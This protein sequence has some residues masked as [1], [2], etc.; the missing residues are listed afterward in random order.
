MINI[1]VFSIMS[2]ITGDNFGLQ[3]G[4]GL[5]AILSIFRFRS[6]NFEQMDIAYFFGA[7]A[8]AT[9]NG[10]VPVGI[11][12]FAVNAIIIAAAFVVDFG[13]T[14]GRM[15]STIVTLDHIPDYLFNEKES[16]RELS[17]KFEIG[18]YGIII[19]EVDYV[20]ETAQVELHFIADKKLQGI[21]ETKVVEGLKA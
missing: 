6:E 20:K 16:K 8:L 3:A 9:V 15:Q 7:V 17:A 13:G 2:M 14:I 11:L 4:L 21:V 5:F 1:F 10:I 19:Q 12:L 18:I